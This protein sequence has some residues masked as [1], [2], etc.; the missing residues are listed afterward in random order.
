MFSIVVDLVE[1]DMGAASPLNPSSAG[2]G[3][4]SSLSFRAMSQFTDHARTPRPLSKA[5]MAL[6]RVES[7]IITLGQ[8]ENKAVPRI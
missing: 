6:T 3:Q 2:M 4:G 5:T 8:L 7:G 1:H